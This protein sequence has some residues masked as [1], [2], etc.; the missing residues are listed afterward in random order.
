METK[1][2]PVTKK[3]SPA[4][5]KPKKKATIKTAKTDEEVKVNIPL[6]DRMIWFVIGNSENN[7]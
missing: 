1:L 6:L 4:K 5:K 3:K 7:I 2:I